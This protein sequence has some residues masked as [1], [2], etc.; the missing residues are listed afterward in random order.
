MTYSSTRRRQ[1]AH[2]VALLQPETTDMEIPAPNFRVTPYGD[3]DP[4]A[5]AALRDTYDTAMLLEWVKRIDRLCN[6]LAPADGLRDELLRLHRMAHT[7]VNGV[8]LIEPAGHTDVWELAQ[9][10]A[11]ELD[12]LAATFSEAAQQV[13]PLVALRPE[14]GE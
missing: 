12:E 3:V 6:R 4:E 1:C 8:V 11:D 10:L 7:V 14:Q 13:R 9:E 2:N 5:L